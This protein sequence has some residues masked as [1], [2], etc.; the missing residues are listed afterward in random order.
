MG[1]LF[2]I[3]RFGCRWCLTVTLSANQEVGL[4]W[5]PLCYRLPTL[6]RLDIVK[7]YSH[8]K[9]AHSTAGMA[10]A[11]SHSNLPGRLEFG[12]IK[13]LCLL[14]AKRSRR[15]SCCTSQCRISRSTCIFLGELR[16]WVIYWLFSRRLSFL[17]NA[18]L[19][20]FAY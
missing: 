9:A 17:L 3:W 12:N 4:F 15:L 18:G 5:E 8:R 11:R 6:Y 20:D 7:V 10:S 2:R 1:P 19:A 13:S 14:I 16:E